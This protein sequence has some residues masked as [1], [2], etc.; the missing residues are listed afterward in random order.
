MSLR[1]SLD[2]KKIRMTYLCIL[3]LH[4]IIS[5]LAI[6]LKIFSFR[7]LYYDAVQVPVSLLDFVFL[8]Q[9]SKHQHPVFCSN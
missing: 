7:L 8:M 2:L 5:N 3:D 6:E 9:Q 4:F 1:I